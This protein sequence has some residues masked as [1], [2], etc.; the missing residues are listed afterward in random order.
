MTIADAR[1]RIA[2]EL[3]AAGLRRGGAALVHA[4]YKALGP[5]PGGAETVVLGLLDALG[6]EGA[7]LMPALSYA[8]VDAG[9]PYFDA[10][11]T[12]S[13]VGW[14]TEHFRGRAGSLRSLHPTHSVC[15]VGAGVEEFLRD[16]HRDGTPCGPNSPFRR[17]RDAGGQVVMLGCGLRPN[18]SMHGV[19]E[20][21][22]PPYLFGGE[23]EYHVRPAAGDAITMRCRRH[24][25]VG[26]EQRYDR[27]ARFLPDG[28]LQ[29]G[30]AL[31][32]TV[33]LIDCRAMWE[34]GEAALREDPFTFVERLGAP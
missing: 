15:G 30:R 28:A 26:Y 19:E 5:V 8:T 22:E 27:L 11:T 23:I 6:P 12:P 29:I 17:L 25:F 31:E 14:L 13:C 18:T 10:R 32:A 7:L 2:D 33:H 16:H 4:S 34:A 3:L 20:R 24:A 9:N 1:E 21:V